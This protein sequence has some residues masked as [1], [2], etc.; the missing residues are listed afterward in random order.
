MYVCKD[1]ETPMDVVEDHDCCALL[2]MHAAIVNFHK[3]NPGALVAAAVAH[4][5]ALSEHS[6]TP[7]RRQGTLLP[8][9]LLAPTFDWAPGEARVAVSLWAR[10]VLVAQLAATDQAF[11]DLPDD[12]AGDVLEFFESTMNRKDFLHFA[13]HHSSQKAKAWV[14]DI[15]TAEVLVSIT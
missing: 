10:S 2:E 12:C 5:A 11:A 1:D 13:T 6:D 14:L 3:L 4:Y 9:C 7:M 8:A 15:V